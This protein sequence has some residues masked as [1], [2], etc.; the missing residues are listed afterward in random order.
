MKQGYRT[1]VH[2]FRVLKRGRL[3]HARTHT[4]KT[5]AKPMSNT[6]VEPEH[7]PTPPPGEANAAMPE[8]AATLPNATAAVHDADHATGSATNASVMGPGRRWLL[9][10]AK[11]AEQGVSAEDIA[12]A[13]GWDYPN[14][15]DEQ[16]E[17]FE[18]SSVGITNY[19]KFNGVREAETN[20][21]TNNVTLRASDDDTSDARGT[22]Q[23]SKDKTKQAEIACD[24]HVRSIE[25]GINKITASMAT[26]DVMEKAMQ[27]R[28]AIG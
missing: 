21:V 15:T 11:L 12:N 19:F 22:I 23:S 27:S 5:H 9:L 13:A 1:M 18:E 16:K 8:A 3:P 14:M 7:L 20:K 17:V 24:K 26:V 28:T 2:R 6:P 4:R 10:R 25:R